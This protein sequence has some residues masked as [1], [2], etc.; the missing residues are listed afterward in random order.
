MG[1]PLPGLVSFVEADDKADADEDKGKLLS[2]C[3]NLN[4]LI[5]RLWPACS[6]VRSRSPA[7]DRPFRYKV[8]FSL[9]LI[10]QP[11]APLRTI[12]VQCSL[13]VIFENRPA[14]A[15]ELPERMSTLC[16]LLKTRMKTT[17]KT[18]LNS[19]WCID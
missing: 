2:I 18:K 11:A 3:E 9:E 17:K 8:D 1:L 19:N 10:C 6:F 16:Y 4:V 14:N 5:G 15:G 13:Q 7:G 12:D